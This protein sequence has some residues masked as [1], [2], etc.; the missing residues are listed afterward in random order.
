MA[1][2]WLRMDLSE[3]GASKGPPAPIFL[4]YFRPN[5]FSA[6]RSKIKIFDLAHYL[7]MFGE[8]TSH[9]LM[10]NA[11]SSIKSENSQNK[12]NSESFQKP[13]VA[14]GMFLYHNTYIRQI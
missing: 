14:S 10:S 1:K 13:A 11:F 12:I 7:W 4:P 8:N 6:F 9:D 3:R 2:K 5:E